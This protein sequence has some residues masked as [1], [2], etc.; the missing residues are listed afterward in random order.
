MHWGGM[1]IRQAPL[2]S[3]APNIPGFAGVES[4]KFSLE[5]HG[6]VMK[7][8]TSRKRAL[9]SSEKWYDMNKKAFTVLKNDPNVML[10][11]NS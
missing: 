5:Y 3:L 1:R 4:V 11:L 7:C 2:R 10:V 9:N 6:M 8:L